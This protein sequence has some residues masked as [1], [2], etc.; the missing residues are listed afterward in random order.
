MEDW[1]FGL[2]VRIKGVWNKFWPCNMIML[3]FFLSPLWMLKLRSQ[4]QS[5]YAEGQSKSICRRT[6]P[7]SKLGSSISAEEDRG[8][9]EINRLSRGCEKF[10]KDFLHNSHFQGVYFSKKENNHLQTVDELSLELL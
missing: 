7:F 4:S 6:W 1:L 8:F 9:G 3:A 5:E 10:S 2:G